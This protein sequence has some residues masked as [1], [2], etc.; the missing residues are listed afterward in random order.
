MSGTCRGHLTE[1]VRREWRLPRP[2]D[3]GWAVEL[4]DFLAGHGLPVR[5]LAAPSPES[6]PESPPESAGQVS[7]SCQAK[8]RLV[9]S[10]PIRV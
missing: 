3:G 7:G 1:L 6:P 2:G 9:G 8:S 5:E 4:E 10:Y